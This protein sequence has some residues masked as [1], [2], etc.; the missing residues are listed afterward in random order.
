MEAD[1][2]AYLVAAHLGID[3][4][5]IVFPRVSSWAGTDL[6]ARPDATI[7]A[8]RGRILATASLVTAHLAAEHGRARESLTPGPVA[9]AAVH[10]PAG[11][12]AVSRGDL[13]RAQETA[14]QFFRRQ[15]PDSWV[16]DYLNARGFGPA[17]QRQWR[18]AT[19]RTDGM[20]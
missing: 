13:V 1:S 3:T 7:R 6:R 11:H 5:A 19:H 12:T 8:V 9:G 16:P 2:V 14:A 4:P 20:H 10:E 15:L 17:V 18:A